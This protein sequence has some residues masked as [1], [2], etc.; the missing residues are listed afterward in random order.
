MK[1]VKEPYE[2]SVEFETK[3]GTELQFKFGPNDDLG[4]SFEIEPYDDGLTSRDLSNEELLALIQWATAAIE[5]NFR[6][7]ELAFS[8][9]KEEESK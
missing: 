5:Y 3:Q 6:R 4:P 7:G 8:R 9:L 1:V 2:Y